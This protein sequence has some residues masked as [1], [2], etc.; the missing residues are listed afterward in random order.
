MEEIT[1]IISRIHDG[2]S[3]NSDRI[4]PKEIKTVFTA[5]LDII[6]QI[7]NISLFLKKL[8]EG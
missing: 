8:P 7:L 5:Y 3:P 6:L 2:I 4:L 1:S